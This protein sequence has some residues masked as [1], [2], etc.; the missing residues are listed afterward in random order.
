ME[1]RPPAGHPE[2]RSSILVTGGAGLIGS[3]LSKS[4][5]S[6]GHKVSVV[7]RLPAPGWAT[8]VNW[9]QTDIRNANWAKILATAAPFAVV[10]LAA[11]SAVTDAQ[12]DPRLAVQTNVLALAKLLE[13]VVAT[14][15]VRRFVFASSSTVY[16]HFIDD[17]APESH[18]T[19]PVE[20]YGRTKLIGEQLVQTYCESFEKDFVIVRPT[21]VYGKEDVA[22]RVVSVLLEQAR[23]GMPLTVDNDGA[24]R[25]DFTHVDDVAQCF[26]RAAFSNEAR[27]RILNFSFGQAHSIMEL[28]NLIASRIPGVQV[29][30]RLT[31]QVR[32]RRGALNSSLAHDLLKVQP[33]YSLEDGLAELISHHLGDPR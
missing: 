31:Q 1:K 11:C 9:F 19:T 21:A 4:L 6:A 7:D 8:G 23:L 28:A 32:P 33:R 20:N 15:D 16:G 17:P 14:A 5:L 30:P 18:S 2:A 25:L 13:A 24:E 12:K 29:R 27:N 26:I 22:R 10:H 3:V